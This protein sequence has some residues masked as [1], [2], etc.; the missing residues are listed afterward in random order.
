MPPTRPPALPSWALPSALLAP[1]GMI[2]GWTVAA[3]VQGPG[4]DPV[5]DTI[6]ALATSG[7]VAPGIMTAGL[8]LTGVGHLTTAAALRPAALPGRLLLAT[9]GAAT[10]AVA[11]LP[12]DAFPGAH[13]AAAG[14]AFVALSLWPAAATRRGATGVLAPVVG[15]LLSG[16]LLVLLGWFVVELQGL[17]PDGGSVTG[18]AER[19]VAGAQS[20]APLAVVLALRRRS[21]G[22]P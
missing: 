17:G 1:V 13:G 2:G 14:V 20:L 8:L 5:Q 6:S 7:V 18:L 22:R 15:G 3:A 16:A 19:V 12:V 4:F 11:A 21:R 9:G 10:V